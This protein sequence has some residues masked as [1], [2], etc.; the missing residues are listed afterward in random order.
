[1]VLVRLAGLVA[2]Y[3]LG[4]EQTSRWSAHAAVIGGSVR[5][6]CSI[7]G[8]PGRQAGRLVI[9]NDVYETL[10]DLNNAG[11]D[12]RGMAKKLRELGFEVILKLNV[13]RRAMGRAPG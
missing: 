4:R 9:G 11:T 7:A 12:A 13:S 6:D 5:L 2:G 10:P 3:G 1:M 8:C